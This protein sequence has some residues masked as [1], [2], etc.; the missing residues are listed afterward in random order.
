MGIQSIWSCKSLQI[1]ELLE[2]LVIDV[3]QCTAPRI[4]AG[5]DTPRLLF[6]Q[7]K[8]HLHLYTRQRPPRKRLRSYGQLFLN[9]IMEGLPTTQPGTGR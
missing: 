7:A 4:D 3:R 1:K 5:D 8:V 6:F 9:P 2:K